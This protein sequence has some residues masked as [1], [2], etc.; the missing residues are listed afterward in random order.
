MIATTFENRDGE[1][2]SPYLQ[3][4]SN[5]PAGWVVNTRRTLDPEY[6]VLHRTSC[7]A[8]SRQTSQMGGN[9]FTG[10]SYIKVCSSEPG[11]LLLW[12]IGHGGSDF[13]QRCSFCQPKRT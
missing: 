9:P 13:S 8:I 6:M 1:G 7:H 5:N 3:W 12:I 4:L 2:D 10:R 11:D